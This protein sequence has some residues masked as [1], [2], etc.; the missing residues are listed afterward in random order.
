[1]K[2]RL[3][4]VLNVVSLALLV[5]TAFAWLRHRRLHETYTYYWCAPDPEQPRRKRM[6]SFEAAARPGSLHFRSGEFW[7]DDPARSEDWDVYAEW[8]YRSSQVF[9]SGPLLDTLSPAE[10]GG[11]AR[12]DRPG[13]HVSF[14]G[15]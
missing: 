10:W 6:G 7:F 5:A 14:L 13:T 2:R 3:F 12:D 11:W 8:R 1:M 9:P 15:I 4:T